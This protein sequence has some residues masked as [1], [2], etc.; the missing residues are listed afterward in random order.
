VIYLNSPQL[1]EIETELAISKYDKSFSFNTFFK[2]DIGSVRS[3]NQ[4]ALY[5]NES[6]ALWLVADGLGG[7]YQG[8]NASAIVVDHVKSYRKLDSLSESAQDL[9]ARFH[10]SNNKCRS[11]YAKKVVGST[12]AT[13][14]FYQ[15]IALFLWVGHSRVYRLRD[16]VLSIMTDD[17]SL[18]QEQV[19]S[20]KISTDMAQRLPKSYI[21]TRAV[22]IHQNLKLELRNARDQLGDRYLVCSDG[23]Y[24]DLTHHE[25]QD[26][27]AIQPIKS[28]LAKIFKKALER[29]GKD[30]ITGILVE[31]S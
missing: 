14:F 16:G 3:S 31:V 28:I 2:T 27:L 21:L 7:H 22:G 23:L 26:F 5:V 20:G 8:G 25:L 18:V 6:Q 4:D 30:N 24:R 29:G 13:L 9:A 15:S 11:M 17:H 10:L 1:E 19:R 12:V